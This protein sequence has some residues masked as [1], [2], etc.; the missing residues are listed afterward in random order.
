MYILKI[1]N[2]EI[3]VF[4]CLIKWKCFKKKKKLNKLKL[5]KYVYCT[6]MLLRTLQFLFCFI[7]SEV[8]TEIY[9]FK[10]K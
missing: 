2:K 10:I 6:C 5:K 9:I 4:A 3:S 7:F 1:I 8:V